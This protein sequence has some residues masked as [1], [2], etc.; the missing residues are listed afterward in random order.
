VKKAKA[1]IQKKYGKSASYID[2]CMKLGRT[3]YRRLCEGI[4]QWVPEVAS[5]GRI[6]S[7]LTTEQ[8]NAKESAA[9]KRAIVRTCR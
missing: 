6:W 4:A 8:R 9:P 2:H 7:K 1:D 5:R 3:H